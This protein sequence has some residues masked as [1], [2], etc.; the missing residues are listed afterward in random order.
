MWTEIQI[1]RFIGRID[2]D[3]LGLMASLLPL[4]GK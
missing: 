2:S 4:T 1:A 3:T